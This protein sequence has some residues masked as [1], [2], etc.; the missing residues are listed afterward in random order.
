MN[1][2]SRLLVTGAGGSI[3]RRLR[4]RLEADGA[5]AVFLVSPRSIGLAPEPTADPAVEVVDITVAA[6][7]NEVVAA[8]RPTGIIHLAS[9]T[10]ADCEADPERAQV[11]N[12]E[13]VR[14]LAG[15]AKANGVSRIVL[16]STSAV[17]GDQYASPVDETGELVLGSRYAQ[18]K[19]D[20]ELV[21]QAAADGDGDF[22]AIS[23]RIFNVY[24]P[25]MSGSLA[26]RLV[27]APAASPVVLAGLDTFVRDYV[28]VDDV[29]E[30]LLRSVEVSLPQPWSIVNVGTGRPVSN[31]ELIAALAPVN[32]VTSDPRA[33]YSCAAVARASALLGFTAVR[34]LNRA[35]V[36]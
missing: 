34:D 20:A 30:A 4:A 8:H 11:V 12:V 14:S 15:I 17:Y 16:A 28:H 6:R 25:G 23:L 35:S 18:T 21:L 33:S 9:V 1:D 26:N 7:L 13:A 2:R 27:A 29:V 19:R 24:G 36:G 22:S 5:D 32:A 3:G 31:R 10:G